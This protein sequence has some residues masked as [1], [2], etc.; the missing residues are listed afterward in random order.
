MCYE[1]NLS[2]EAEIKLSFPSLD[3]SKLFLGVMKLPVAVVCSHAVAEV[4]EMAVVP[5][6]PVIVHAVRYKLRVPHSRRAGLAVSGTEHIMVKK[7]LEE[8]FANT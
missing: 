7:V 1:K 5:V 6:V 8:A 3:T 2:R 4:T